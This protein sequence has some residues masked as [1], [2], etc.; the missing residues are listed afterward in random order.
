MPAAPSSR[1][2]SY[3]VLAVEVFFLLI[4]G[5]TPFVDNYAHLGGLVGGVFTS[6]AAIEK[7]DYEEFFGKDDDEEVSGEGA[8]LVDR[9]VAL[10]RSFV[11]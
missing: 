11:P 9:H 3:V 10:K 6:M 4:V 8:F 2:G 7:I 1:C 5:L